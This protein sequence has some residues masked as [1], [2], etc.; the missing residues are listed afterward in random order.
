[1]RLTT[2][3]DKRVLFFTISAASIVMLALQLK[4]NKLFI[5]PCWLVGLG[6]SSYSLYLGHALMITAFYQLGLRDVLVSQPQIV[7]EMGFLA[8]IVFML[9]ASHLYY[10]YIERPIYLK[11]NNLRLPFTRRSVEPPK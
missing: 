4:K 6:D 10:T 1:M 7:T 5:S 11:A 9:A 8:F 3:L 2:N